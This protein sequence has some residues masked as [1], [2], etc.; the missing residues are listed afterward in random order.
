MSMPEAIHALT[1]AQALA[2]IAVAL[3]HIRLARYG[4]SAEWSARRWVDQNLAEAQKALRFAEGHL[5]EE[6]AKE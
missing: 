4:V 6:L 3:E 5:R 2:E 1:P